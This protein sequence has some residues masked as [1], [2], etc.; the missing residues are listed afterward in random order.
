MPPECQLIIFTPLSPH[1]SAAENK[2]TP[3]LMCHG[4]CDQVVNYDFGKRR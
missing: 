4:D 1:D 2:G 3:V